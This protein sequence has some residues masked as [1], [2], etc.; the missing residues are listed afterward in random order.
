METILTIFFQ[1]I[2]MILP[3]ARGE[4][5]MLPVRSEKNALSVAARGTGLLSC[6]PV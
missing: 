5:G 4:D 2:T 1:I 6:C 3:E